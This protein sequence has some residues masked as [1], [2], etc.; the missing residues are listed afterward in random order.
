[1]RKSQ[2]FLRQFA[3]FQERV[4]TSTVIDDQKGKEQA[5]DPQPFA[6]CVFFHISNLTE[7]FAAG[8]TVPTLS[9][10]LFH[11]LSRTQ[12]NSISRETSFKLLTSHILQYGDVRPNYA[13]VDVDCQ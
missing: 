13:S 4:E 12:N 7:T 10:L 9:Y 3:E 8:S 11:K 6:A 2:L 1:M 5:L